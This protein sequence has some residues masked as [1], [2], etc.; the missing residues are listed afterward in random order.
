M[1]AMPEGGELNI[2]TFTESQ[3]GEVV[4]EVA[5]NGCGMSE[6]V[7]A[8]IFD[9]LYTT[10]EQGRGTGLGLVIVSQLM[11]EHDGQI[12]VESLPGQGAKF[13]LHFPVIE[14]PS[15]TMAKAEAA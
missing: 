5:D 2:K 13:G 10:K 11:R 14:N 15:G 9:P 3:S 6:E 12:E 4:V 1:D 8:R 7:R